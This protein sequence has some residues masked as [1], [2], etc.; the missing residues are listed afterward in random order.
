MGITERIDAITE[1]PVRYRYSYLPAPKSCKIEIT[2]ACN[3]ACQFCVKSIQPENVQMDR[4][5]YSRLLREMRD[6]GVEELGVFYIGESFTCGW[7]PDAIKEA[8]DIGFP[9]VFLTTNGSIATPERVQKCMEAG[10]DSLKF[11]INFYDAGQLH[12]IARVTSR[13]W[14]KAIENLKAARKVRDEGGYK[15]GIY[16]SAIA[17]DGEQGKKMKAVV[18]DIRGHVDEFYWLPL[19]GMS[20]AAKEAGMKPNPGN[21]GRLDAMRPPLPCWAVFTEAHIT[22]SGKLAACCF[23]TGSDKDLVMAD[24]TKVSFKDGWNSPEFRALRQAHLAK[25]VS[26]T[27]C[28]G[29]IQC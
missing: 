20:G 15:C 18:D 27:G 12:E 24:L 8:K 11:S 17:F 1:I 21:P 13:F 25:D 7:L 29:C 28:A 19:Y 6:Y 10:L 14:S 3:Y 9:Y 22:A 5:L 2:S 16:A 23:G 26:D 4:R